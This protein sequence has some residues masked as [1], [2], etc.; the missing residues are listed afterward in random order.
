MIPLHATA[1]LDELEVTRDVLPEFVRP[2]SGPT[3][4]EF[5][6]ACKA[7]FNPEEIR[8]AIAANVRRLPRVRHG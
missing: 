7:V 3:P 2:Y 5:S 6:E 4:E 1:P 8:R